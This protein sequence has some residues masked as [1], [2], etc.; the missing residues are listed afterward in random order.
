V[1][2]NIRACIALLQL[3]AQRNSFERAPKSGQRSDARAAA[4]REAG[5]GNQ[6]SVTRLDSFFKL[7][8]L[9]LVLSKVVPF[10]VKP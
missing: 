5:D 8:I 1:V 6:E 3:S 4:P 9:I 7:E 2:T 10:A